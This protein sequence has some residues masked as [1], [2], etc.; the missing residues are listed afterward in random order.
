[1]YNPLLHKDPV[2]SLIN[3][4]KVIAAD[5]CFLQRI[6]RTP[7]LEDYPYL[8]T[9]ANGVLLDSRG[10][11][12]LSNLERVEKAGFDIYKEA[13]SLYICTLYGTLTVPLLPPQYQYQ[14]LDWR[15]ALI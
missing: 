9:T 1:M 12:L 13:N 15:T 7:N 2:T 6:H 14:P 8:T 3:Q 5:L 11:W 4:L 10:K